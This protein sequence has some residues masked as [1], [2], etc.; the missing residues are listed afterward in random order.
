M[1]EYQPLA[2]LPHGLDAFTRAYLECAEWAGLDEEAEEALELS[3]SPKWD[4][5]TIKRVTEECAQFQ[6]DCA[7]ALE[8]AYETGYT[9][10]QAGHDFHLTRNGHG[11][12]FW[13]RGLGDV[14]ARLT[15]AAHAWG[16]TNVTY[17]GTTELLRE[18]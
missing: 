1:P 3:V 8:T 10:E 4:L 16:S 14:G 17:D 12:G 9:P 11:A 2:R 5:D 18:E 13:D 15:S 7:D 6:A